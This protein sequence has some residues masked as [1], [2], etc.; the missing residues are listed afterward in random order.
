MNLD[1][2]NKR[3]KRNNRKTQRRM[4]C[5]PGMK[6]KT[7]SRNTCYTKNHLSR[8]KQAY[9][10]NHPS[11]KIN[12]NVPDSIINELRSKLE[13]K[14]EDCWLKQLNEKERKSIDESVF[15]PDH[16]D[17]WKDNPTEWLSNYDILSV[18]F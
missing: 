7:A 5:H 2:S 13:C 18:S 17:K 11:K 15:A 9:N 8:I 3:I 16:P 6:G 14:K 4:N 1:K 10:K 12:S